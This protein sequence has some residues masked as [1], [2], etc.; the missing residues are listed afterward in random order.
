MLPINARAR[1]F[2]RL[3]PLARAGA[4]YASGLCVK[5]LPPDKFTEMFARRALTA[6]PRR[7][8][9]RSYTEGATG[10]PRS[11]GSSDSFTV[12]TWKAW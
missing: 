2:P 10:A 6:V 11:D 4:K 9:I 12:C 8:F 7:A 5:P 1:I 3:A